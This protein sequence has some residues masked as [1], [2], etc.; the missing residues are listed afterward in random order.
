MVQT[1]RAPGDRLVYPG[2]GAVVSLFKGYDAGY[3]GL[4]PPYIV[5][6]EPQGRFSEA[7]FLGPRYKPFATG[8]DP[9]QTP[10]A[11]EGVVAPGHHRRAPAQPPRPAAQARHA[12]QRHAAATR[13]SRRSSK[14]E[15][16]GL[17]PDPRRRRQGVR[18]LAGEGRA[19]RPLRPQHVRPVLPD[20][21][22]AGRARRALRHDQL[23]GLG[24]AQ[25]ALPDHAPQAARAGQ[26]AG[27]AACRTC[28]SAACST[29][30]SSGGAASSAARRRCEWEPPWNG[31]RGHCGAA[32]S[33]R[34]S[35]AAASRAA[36]SSAPRTPDGRRGQGP[37]RLSVRPDRQHVRAAG[38]RPR[39]EAAATPRASTSASRRRRQRRSVRGPAEGD[40]V[41]HEATRA[42]GIGGRPCS[43]C[44]TR[45]RRLPAHGQP[46]NSP[47][48][49]YAFPAG[50][51]Q[52]TTVQVTVGGRYLEGVSGAVCLRPRACT[53]TSSATT[54]RFAARDPGPP[55]EG[56]G[57]AEGD[58]DAGGAP[59]A[60]GDP[61]PP[62]RLPAA[63]RE[64]RAVRDRDARGHDRRR[65]GARPVAASPRHAA[66]TVESR[67]LQRRP[68][69]G[70]RRAGT[71]RDRGVRR[72]TRRKRGQS[73]GGARICPGSR[74]AAAR[75]R[76]RR[77]A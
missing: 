42:R 59:A 17:R 31:G 77:S 6:T 10:F 60:R 21:A 55:R 35:P 20:G 68:T 51:Q 3:K 24:H 76:S 72:W 74:R 32:S 18:P 39:G 43:S 70:G 15:D 23:Q 53:P 64:P 73:R 16:A 34:W 13:R 71:R 52:G 11:V 50:G 26:G 44:G 75:R 7:G 29:A 48:A 36:T 47:H 4:I 1:G 38:H 61:R 69:P 67:G 30:R 2:V 58:D 66:R 45:G 46:L 14:C 5:L 9:A 8:G 28:P 25:A 49:G 33:P 57:T 40:C 37:A 27:H 54:S 56:A 65:C 22:P 63:Q 12:G 62:R 41:D 19:A